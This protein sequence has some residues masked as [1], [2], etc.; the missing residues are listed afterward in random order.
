MLLLIHYE[1]RDRQ[2]DLGKGDKDLGCGRALAHWNR[3]GRITVSSVQ[4]K[5]GKEKKLLKPMSQTCVYPRIS[6]SG[7]H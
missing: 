5:E 6:I 1:I 4:E 7:I 3:S 2:K